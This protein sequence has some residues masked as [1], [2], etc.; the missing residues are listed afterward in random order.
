MLQFKPTN[1]I[2]LQTAYH[3]LRFNAIE[4]MPTISTTVDVAKCTRIADVASNERYSLHNV[5][6]YHLL[7]RNEN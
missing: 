5:S 6:M 7:G 2:N 4:L 1:S 3:F